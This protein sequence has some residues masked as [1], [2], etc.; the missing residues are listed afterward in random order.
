MGSVDV[1]DDEER[2]HQE[3][4]SV[5]E[6]EI[7]SE[8]THLS[9]LTEQLTTRLGHGV[10]SKTVPLS[11]PEGNVTKIRLE[12]TGKS[13]VDDDLVEPT[14]DSNNANHSTESFGETESLKEEHDL[15]EGEEHEDGHGVGDSGE[16]RSE[17]LAA[18]LE[19][20]S[21]TTSHSE[22]GSTDSHVDE[23]GSES[24]DT[25]TDERV[26]RSESSEGTVSGVLLAQTDLRVDEQVRDQSDTDQDKR[27]DELRPHNVLELSTGNVSSKL[28]RGVSKSLALV[29]SDTGT[30]KTAESDPRL[31]VR[32][33]VSTRQPAKVVTVVDE[34]IVPRE[35]MRVVNEGRNAES[36]Q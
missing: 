25:D 20:R 34:E 11:S 31:S 17:L 6:N 18:R 21:H 24:D 23:D 12:L 28:L 26:G 3:Q 1:R 32:A 35:L 30:R 10:Q 29:T 4:K 2:E 33:R 36:E 7:R 9:S 19:E 15:E 16:D 5:S 8:V 27:T 14:L 22:Q 13:K